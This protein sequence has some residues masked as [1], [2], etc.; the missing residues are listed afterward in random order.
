M[1]LKN[2][3]I[4]EAV[5]DIDCDMPPG[6]DL[7]AL[8]KAA[9]EAFEPQYSKFR[10]MFLE[11][12]RLEAKGA[13][14]SVHTAD[15]AIQALQFA[16]DDGK[17][18]VQVRGQGF[19]FNRLAQYTTLD[20]YLPE[21]ERTWRLFLDLA[22]PVQVCVIRL[23]YINRILLP[24]TKQGVK[25][26]EYLKAS[27]QLADDKLL[28]S[29]FLNQYTAVEAQSG[30]EVTVVVTGQS[31][32]GDRAPIIFDNCVG[33]LGVSPSNSADTIPA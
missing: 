6:F 22:L 15:R 12:H 13:E 31:A 9:R 25:L 26:E 21:I 30:H 4:V 2:V 16:H 1:K 3:P 11:Q 19:S 14:P 17:Q 18:L 24:M 10:A 20:D 7:V 32:E 8:E 5:V 23:R 28:L 29:S 27:L 33:V